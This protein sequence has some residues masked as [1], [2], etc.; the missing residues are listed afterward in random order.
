MYV[1]VR[2][3]GRMYI[4]VCHIHSSVKGRMLMRI[5]VCIPT[6]SSHRNASAR[7]SAPRQ[8]I[9]LLHKFNSNTDLCVCVCVWG[10]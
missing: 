4:R 6:R 9:S 3:H 2:V 8:L 7:A 1:C 10:G 5:H